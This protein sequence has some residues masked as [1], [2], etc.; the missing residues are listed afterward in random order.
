MKKISPELI[1]IVVSMLLLIAGVTLSYFA[2]FKI[3]PIHVNDLAE[4]QKFEQEEKAKNSTVTFY[5]MPKIQTNIENNSSRLLQAEMTLALEPEQ[6]ISIDSI[7][8]YESLIMDL[9]IN[10]VAQTTMDQL[11][12]VSGKIILAEKIK[13][14]TNEI[15]QQKAI[16][17]VL[18]STFS[19]QLQ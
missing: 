17:R 8:K 14:G 16:K 19:V 11:D 2:F 15:M 13:I 12:N 1:V 5:T 6:G 4:K 7:K 18:F 3:Q 9:V 10:T